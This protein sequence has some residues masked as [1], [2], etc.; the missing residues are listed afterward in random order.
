MGTPAAAP[1]LTPGDGD[2][3]AVGFVQELLRTQGFTRLP[4]MRSSSYGHFGDQT[5]EAVQQYRA[6]AG[7]GAGSDVDGALISRL[8][9]GDVPNPLACRGY[10]T[11]RLA[12]EFTP[13][14]G[15]VA[16]TCLF[17]SGGR[18]ACL[19]LNTDRQGLSF[20]IIQ[21][22]QKPGRLHEILQAFED[23]EPAAFQKL[24][25]GADLVHG[26]L[27]WTARPFGGVDPATGLATQ[28]AWS[29]IDDPWKGCLNQMGHHPELQKVQIAVALADFQASL[30][31]LR[32]ATPLIVSQRGSA[33]LL[34]LANQHGDAGAHRIYDSVVRPGMEESE[35]LAAMAQ[36]SLRRVGAQYGQGSAEAASTETR[37]SFFRTAPYLSDAP[38]TDA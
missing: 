32:P 18:F 25:G 24:A 10:L 1:V 34:D 37:R 2:A 16:L 36:E 6:T 31:R 33:F 38:G 17:E 27:D 22:A 12:G 3:A 4:D 15:V 26:L 19:T 13:M 9:A 29:L 23:W 20:G 35:A 14:A 21:W 5:R 11:L 30:D 8:V 28:S 7:L